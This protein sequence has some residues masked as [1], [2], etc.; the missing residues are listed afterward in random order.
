MLVSGPIATN[1]YLVTD[2][3]TGESILI[4]APQDVTGRLGPLLG[5]EG[6]LVLLVDTHG[7]WDHVGDNAAVA[8]LTGAP[9]AIHASDAGMLENGGADGFN[10]PFKLLPSRADRLLDEGEKIVFGSSSL[11]VMH[12]PG[13]TAGGICLYD[14]KEGNLFSGDTLFNGSYGRTDLPNSSVKDMQA[15]L[16]RLSGLPPQTRVYPGHGETTTI[17]E[18]EWLT[19]R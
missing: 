15:S 6:K 9:L 19:H 11:L 5:K 10:L 1:S 13:H 3:G 16:A 18:Q 14:E 7:H 2:E 12:T 8:A 17:G 4:D